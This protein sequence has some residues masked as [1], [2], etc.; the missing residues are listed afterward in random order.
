[1]VQD[2]YK[3]NYVMHYKFLERPKGIDIFPGADKVEDMFVRSKSKSGE[4]A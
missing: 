4:G 1:M 2:N 3:M